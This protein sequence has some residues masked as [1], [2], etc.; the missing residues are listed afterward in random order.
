MYKCLKASPCQFTLDLR[1]EINAYQW[2]TES[3]GVT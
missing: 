2:Q 3:E 1:P